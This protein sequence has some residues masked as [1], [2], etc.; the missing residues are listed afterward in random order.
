MGFSSPESVCVDASTIHQLL[1]V[2]A[3]EF[4]ARL[5]PVEVSYIETLAKDILS[6]I[7]CH[8]SYMPIQDLIDLNIPP[9]R[10]GLLLSALALCC[11]YPKQIDSNASAYFLASRYLLNY[12]YVKPSLDLCI[13][14]YLQH[15]YLLKT[16]PDNQDTTA[17]TMAIHT[18]HDL[19][20]NKR[21]SPDRCTLPAKLYLF[22]YFH[23]Q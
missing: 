12:C 21:G 4:V 15:L 2:S 11:I 18:A 7:P 20:I 13:A 23:D 19:K 16:G 6:Q 5:S 8:K 9:D 1:S 22:L 10:L 17:L 14:Y 3:A